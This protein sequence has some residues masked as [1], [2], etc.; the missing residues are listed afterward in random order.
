MQME[1]EGREQRMDQL[2]NGKQGSQWG[3]IKNTFKIAPYEAQQEG[4]T[5]RPVPKLT[6]GEKLIRKPTEKEGRR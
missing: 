2:E 6:V 5:A 3:Q 4:K 1:K